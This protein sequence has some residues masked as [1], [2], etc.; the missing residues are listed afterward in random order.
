MNILSGSWA[1]IWKCRIPWLVG[2]KKCEGCGRVLHPERF[3]WGKRSK[4]GYRYRESK[5][6][7]CRGYKR[8]ESPVF[9]WMGVPD[10]VRSWYYQGESKGVKIT[11]NKIRFRDWWL[12]TPD[13]CH[14]CGVALSEMGD[15]TRKA[16]SSPGY[17]KSL[18]PKNR[19][20]ENILKSR[21]MTIDRADN[22]MP[23]CDGNLRKACWVCNN[24]KSDKLSEEEML[25]VAPMIRKRIMS[26]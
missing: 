15:Y 3:L 7:V 4:T 16:S 21:R 17:F 10:L 13:V 18:V 9:D 14:Y 23:Y 8:Y 24:T 12:N 26:E 20:G 1:V 22:S 11:A 25:I 19:I 6:K 5:C 2:G